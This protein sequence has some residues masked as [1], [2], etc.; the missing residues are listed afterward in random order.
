MREHVN[1]SVFALGVKIE[2]VQTDSKVSLNDEKKTQKI[3]HQKLFGSAQRRDYACVESTRCHHVHK[4]QSKQ[5]NE[6]TLENKSSH[7][8]D[9]NNNYNICMYFLLEVL[10]HFP[11]V[12]FA[13]LLFP[14]FFLL[15][16]CVHSY[17]NRRRSMNACIRSCFALWR[18]FSIG[19]VQ[20]ELS[21]YVDNRRL[22]AYITHYKSDLKWILRYTRA[23]ITVVR[24][25]CTS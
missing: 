24:H 7:L 21:H 4:S 20:H 2:I 14:Y 17:S 5:K 16:F 10:P 18:L 12:S 11:F 22:S 15:C 3:K 23:D 19:L 1:M 9:C 6:H 25:T 8:S 13:H